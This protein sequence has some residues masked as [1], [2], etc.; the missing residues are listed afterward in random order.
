[1]DV[2]GQDRQWDPSKGKAPQ[3]VI[4]KRSIGQKRKKNSKYNWLNFN[5]D[6]LKIN[7]KEM[8]LKQ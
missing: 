8:F 7:C 2:P 4:V 3:R 1:M 5:L 6:T